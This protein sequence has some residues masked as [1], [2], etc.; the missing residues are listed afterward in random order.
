MIG[1]TDMTSQA[2]KAI[3]Q[4]K[5]G[6][7]EFPWWE[8]KKDVQG[9]VSLHISIPSRDNTV[10][11]LTD[12]GLKQAIIGSALGDK[13]K[14]SYN[15]AGGDSLIGRARDKMAVAFLESGADWQLQI[16]DDIIFPFGM[17]QELAKFYA[18]WMS[19]ETLDAFLGEGVFRWAFSLNAIDEILRSG[20]N[21]GKRIVG[22][23]YF[24]RGGSR[25]INQAA[26][27][28][29]EAKDGGFEVEFKLRPDNYIP[30]DKLA[31]GFLLTHKSVYEDIMKGFPNLEYQIPNVAPGKS[32]FAF[33][34]TMV[35]EE[36]Y[37]IYPKP[38]E[39]FKP[40]LSEDKLGFYR[41]EDYAFSWLAK[42]V[43]YDPCLNMNILLGHIGTHIYSWLDR[44]ILQKLLLQAL[45]NPTH[46]MAREGQKPSVTTK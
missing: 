21:D 18:N 26:S 11:L 14:V 29:P 8:P 32:T 41:S 10:S 5:G 17:G 25:N 1:K 12:N 35:T 46:F 7:E 9:D 31:T 16:D 19:P 38:G 42:Q 45:D 44:P 20:I 28:M 13:L 39:N 30:T 33:Y 27:V 2:E 15:F 37:M 24:W 23:L 40:H 43:G 22:G 36:R 34:H 6:M 4:L 3:N